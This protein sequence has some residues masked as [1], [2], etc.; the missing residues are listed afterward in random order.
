MSETSLEILDAREKV[1]QVLSDLPQLRP[2]D[3]P[4]T[5][6]AWQKLMRLLAG[7]SQQIEDF[8]GEDDADETRVNGEED[9]DGMN[10]VILLP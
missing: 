5:R 6:D 9:K 10:E 3:T 2:E 4:R 8:H 7:V 1:K